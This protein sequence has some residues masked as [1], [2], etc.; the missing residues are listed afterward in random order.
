MTDPLIFVSSRASVPERSAMWR[1][2][3]DDEGW[4]IVSTWIDEAGEGETADQ[5]ELW[6][7][8]HA[9][10]SACDG[11]ILYAEPGD[12]P[13]KGSLVEVGVAIGMNKPVVLVLSDWSAFEEKG[14]RP[15]GSWMRHPYCMPAFDL[16]EARRCISV[17]MESRGI[18]P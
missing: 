13:L 16:V 12:F 18:R 11:L 5:G 9:E 4:R 10:I 1:K 3:R 6:T 8:I 2:L 7:R 17:S 15:L 14:C